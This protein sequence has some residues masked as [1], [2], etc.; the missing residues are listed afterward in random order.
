M[1][2]PERMQASVLGLS[3]AYVRMA[4]RHEGGRFA[5]HPDLDLQSLPTPPFQIRKTARSVPLSSP[6][7]THVHGVK[8]MEELKEMCDAAE[9][10]LSL[11]G[12]EL[13]RPNSSSGK[14]DGSADQPPK[15]HEGDLYLCSESLNALEGALG[16]VC[17]AVDYVFGPGT[18]CRAFSCVRPPGHHCSSNYPSGFCWLNNVHVGIAHAAMTHG[19]THAAILD[20]DLHHGDGSQAITWDR[21]AKAAPAKNAAQ[22]KKTSIGYFSLHDINSYPCEDGEEGKV[23]NASVCLENAHGQS[24]WN[25]HLEPW[26]TTAEFWEL[27]NTKYA[28]LIEKARA[29]IRFHTQRLH[30]SLNGPRPKAAI[31]LS[32]GFDASEWEGAGMQRH[33]INV[34]TDFYSRFT[35]DVVRLSQE[36]GLGVGGRVVSVLEGGYSDRAL[37]SGVLSHLS[38][39]ADTRGSDSAPDTNNQGARL[40]TEMSNRLGLSDE[41]N[42]SSC[43]PTPESEELAA[44]DTQWWALP[45]LE[46]LEAQARPPTP[47][48]VRKP[49]DKNG[50]TYT[51][52][53]QAS[54]AKAVAP[55]RERLSNGPLHATDDV[56]YVPHPIPAVDWATAAFEMSKALI[57]ADIRTSSCQH[58]ELKAEGNRNRQQRLSANAADLQ[59][60][61]ANTDRGHMRLRERK[62]KATGTPEEMSAVK[63]PR[64]A[65][66]HSRR[67]TIAS[68]SDLPDA[69]TVEKPEAH[70]AETDAATAT[71]SR[72]ASA[73]LDVDSTAGSPAT[74]A[75]SQSNPREAPS[76]RKSSKEHATSSRPGSS[77]SSKVADKKPRPALGGRAATSTGAP[78]SSPRKPSSTPRGSRNA[79]TKFDHGTESRS[80][81]ASSDGKNGENH[82]DVENLTQG[83]KKMSIKLKM[84]TPEQHA[85][86]IKAAE[87]EMKRKKSKPSKK[88]HGSTKSEKQS[89]AGGSDEKEEPPASEASVVPEQPSQESADSVNGAVSRD[90]TSSTPEDSWSIAGPSSDAAPAANIA[91]SR[92]SSNDGNASGDTSNASHSKADNTNML[93]SPLTPQPA[94]QD[95]MQPEAIITKSA[96]P[97][98]EVPKSRPGMDKLPVFTSTSVIPFAPSTS[99]DTLTGSDAIDDSA[100]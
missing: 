14:S 53:T 61:T 48:P 72:P 70:P 96:P 26:K 34:P 42:R 56:A 90:Q 33:K 83:V 93:S 25:V 65:S 88:G 77:A 52:P 46:E 91:E 36:E 78:R 94:Q 63:T 35:A 18:P 69:S 4:K 75:F 76:S 38:G 60:S 27:Y 24:I 11:N 85:A 82:Q 54:V 55:V 89:T 51:A 81:P 37:T 3:A 19:L 99:S 62:P 84:P 2:R 74:K 6:A 100:K 71:S 21:N 17:E 8:W 13:V 43:L 95:V 50:P 97:T 79:A 12:K 40:A 58:A 67:T 66:R 39:L 15:L 31:F 44:F 28:I 20:F 59:H 7:V 29:F 32:A 47:A 45:M 16:G 87:E 86:R 30:E 80:Y 9:S 23:R 68:V 49:R 22:H 98:A 10:R 92:P 73:A 57:P 5:P 1:E 64:P 41:Y